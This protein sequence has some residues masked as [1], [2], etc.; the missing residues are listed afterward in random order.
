ML[1]SD[2]FDSKDKIPDEIPDEESPMYSELCT[3]NGTIS[4]R[5]SIRIEWRNTSLYSSQLFKGI[6]KILKTFFLCE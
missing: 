3:V 5:N 2:I 6:I 1:V 4:Y